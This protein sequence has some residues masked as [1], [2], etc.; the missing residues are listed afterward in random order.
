MKKYLP[1]LI[2]AALLIISC[3]KKNTRQSV[4]TFAGSGA[5]GAKD[6]KSDQATFSNLKGIALD[7]AGNMYVADSR[8]NLIRKID[9]DGMV[10]TIAGSGAAGS[11]DGKGTAASFFDPAA[12][13][14]D[15][16]GNIYVADKENNLIRKISPQNVVTTIAGRTEK[17]EEYGGRFPVF[18]YPTGL[19]VDA[20]GTIY[21]ADSFHDKIRKIGADGKIVVLA[22]NGTPGSN[23]GPGKAATFFVP[24]GI[25]LDAKGD[26]YVADTYNNLIRKISKAGVVS[27]IAGRTRKG[28]SNGKGTAASFFHPE[29]LTV[30]KDGNIYVADSGN[31]LIRKISPA[32]MVTTLAGNGT[33]GV[34]NGDVKQASF[35]R[36]MGIA[37]D[38]LGNIYVA[39]YQNN[40]IRKITQ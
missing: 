17:N 37:A 39:D 5:V 6:G 27:T 23:D 38:T 31:N 24:E 32:G 10:S 9:A 3:G 4:T 30:D 11:A 34:K 7:P 16:N 1:L 35:F 15:K 12:V 25:A 8:N 36:P 19:A 26:L 18:D 21:I 13:A 40:A 28:N 33:R 2:I 22:G 14:V 29:A 20:S